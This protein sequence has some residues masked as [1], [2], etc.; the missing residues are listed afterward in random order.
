MDASWLLLFTHYVQYLSTVILEDLAATYKGPCFCSLS[1]LRKG[2]TNSGSRWVK[3]PIVP[4]AR[5]VGAACGPGPLLIAFV[6]HCHLPPIRF[7][8][9]GKFRSGK[10][11]SQP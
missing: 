7:D 10:L 2:T 5:I 9:L 11:S 3:V 6:F 1:F 8:P 4:V